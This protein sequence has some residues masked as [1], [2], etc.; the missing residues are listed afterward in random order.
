[1]EN[2]YL[3]VSKSGINETVLSASMSIDCLISKIPYLSI[4]YYYPSHFYIRDTV[5]KRLHRIF[6]SRDSGY[7]LG[8][9]ENGKVQKIATL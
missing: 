5:Y 2:Q 7:M 9:V 8:E 6:K 4:D 3:L 1:M